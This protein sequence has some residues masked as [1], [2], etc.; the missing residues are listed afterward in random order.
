MNYSCV[1]KNFVS[2]AEN[3]TVIVDDDGLN[4]ITKELL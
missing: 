3:A 4:R 2:A 1:Y